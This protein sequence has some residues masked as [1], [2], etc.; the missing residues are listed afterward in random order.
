MENR[1]RPILAL[2]Q[3]QSKPESAHQKYGSKAEMDKAAS[4][5]KNITPV[6]TLNL[7]V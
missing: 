7:I 3:T 1:V 5:A 4:I 6:E 2:T